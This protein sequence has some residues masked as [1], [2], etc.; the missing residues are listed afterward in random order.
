MDGDLAGSRRHPIPGK[1]TCTGFAAQF[2]TRKDSVRINANAL[3]PEES[4]FPAA[5]DRTIGDQTT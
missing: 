1:R 5:T 3:S 4:K 2:L